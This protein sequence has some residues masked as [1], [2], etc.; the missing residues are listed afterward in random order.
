MPERWSDYLT[1]FMSALA[2][3]YMVYEIDRRQRKLREIFD[4]LDAEDAAVTARLED[5]VASGELQPYK[6]ATL[7]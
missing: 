1:I 6:G 3:G 2:V 4:V 5:M 7:A